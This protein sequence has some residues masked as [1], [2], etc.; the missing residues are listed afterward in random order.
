MPGISAP[1]DRELL[2][3][4]TKGD[5]QAYGDLVTR[6]H[7]LVHAVCRRHC[8]ALVVEDVAQA[9]FLV[10]ARRPDQAVQAPA[11]G[12][13]LVRTA[14]LISQQARRND[15]ARRR[16]ERRAAAGTVLETRVASSDND[17]ALEAVEDALQELPERQR[18]ALTLQFIV[19]HSQE[20]VAAQLGLQVN[21]VKQLIHR[22]IETLRG[23]LRRRGMAV[24]V[25]ALA[26][27]FSASEVQAAEAAPAATLDP[28]SLADNYAHAQTLANAFVA[29]SGP[30]VPGWV[31]AGI[32]AALAS[33]MVLSVW[34]ALPS[35]SALPPEATPRAAAQASAQPKAPRPQPAPAVQAEAPSQ[36]PAFAAGWTV[37][38]DCTGTANFRIGHLPGAI[39]V[40]AH[41][42]ELPALLPRDRAARIVAYGSSPT[43]NIVEA[44]AATVRRLGYTDVEIYREGLQGWLRAGGRLETS[45]DNTPTF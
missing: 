15:D 18:V 8:P 17:V 13:W 16:I 9:V 33:V 12:A 2:L 29:R 22:G 34:L 42:Q 31:A 28:S 43:C 20:E 44:V 24:P 3:A 7:G 14:W 19:G 35:A 4:W 45:V 30:L 1:A 5:E 23:H 11:L 21:A 32:I 26:A 36:V 6:Y 37:I 41:Q 27:M 40:E 10:L 39:D 38:L 25:T